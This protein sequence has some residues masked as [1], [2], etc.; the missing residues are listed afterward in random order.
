M[1][2]IDVHVHPSTSPFSYEKRWGKEVAEF[3]PKYYRIQERIR[4]EEE[5]A[6]EFRSLDIKAVLV[7]WDAQAQSGFDT[8]TFNDEV[9]RLIRKFPDVFI[10]G[11]AMI[12][13]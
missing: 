4:T 10:G 2:A 8:S 5:M 7:G 3:L 13:P 9:A 1:K 6:E 11:W 12:D